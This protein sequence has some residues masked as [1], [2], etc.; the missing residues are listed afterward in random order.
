M[1]KYTMIIRDEN[2]RA[3]AHRV[4]DRAPINYCVTFHPI[5]RTIEQNNAMWPMLADVSRQ[6]THLGRFLLP[7]QWKPLFCAS[8][9]GEAVDMMP[10]LDG[11]MLVPLNLRTSTFGKSEFSDLL[12]VI[13]L[14]AATKGVTLTDREAA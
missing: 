6:T 11:R 4:L 7:N 10:S 12:E 8:L 14:Y 5:T 2:L 1:E 9:Y 13:K 3:K